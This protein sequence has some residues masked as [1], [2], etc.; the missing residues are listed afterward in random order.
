[1][2]SPVESRVRQ[3]HQ[4]SLIV[5][6]HS[7]YPV[8]MLLEYHQ[9]NP[10]AF[11]CDHL[12]KLR[13]AG[14]RIE[15]VTVGGDFELEGLDL[16]LPMVT[17]AIIDCAREQ[18]TAC[19][20]E[21]VVIESA[22]DLAVLRDAS[23][24]GIMF[25][26]EGAAPVTPDLSML[27]TYHRLGVRSMMLT[28]NE[29]NWFADGCGEPSTGGL[30]KL[31]RELVREM[32]R[33]CMTLDV[34]HANEQTFFD[35]IDLYEGVPIASHSN[36]RP[37]RDHARNLTDE[38]IKLIAQRSGVI[39]MNFLARFIDDDDEKA[40]ADRIVDH[41][42]YIADLV[43]VDHIGLGPDYADY[44]MDR[45]NEWAR[46]QNLPVMRYAKELESVS[47]L[48]RLTES[49]VER[50]FSDEDL[51][52]ILGENFIRAYRANLSKKAEGATS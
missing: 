27:R 40:T 19:G 50:G 31:G 11:Q 2:D 45:L 18:M 14:V 13:A 47:Q 36:V 29:R 7:D 37:L 42:S 22:S 51:K 32:S 9:G 5:D 23:K 16:R 30:S 38:Q 25:A 52:K 28:H 49:L 4:T 8:Q 26:L 21:V 35:A 34:S 6:A 48:P 12:P 24:I 44:Y 3:L 15:T 10:R 39:G 17:L 41:V 46:K 20:D 1:M 43:G 33:L